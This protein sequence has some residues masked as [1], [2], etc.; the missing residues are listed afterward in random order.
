MTESVY[1]VQCGARSPSIANFCRNCGTPLVHDVEPES[2]KPEKLGAEISNEDQLSASADD[3][4]SPSRVTGSRRHGNPIQNHW[5]G[6]YSPPVALLVV[7]LAAISVVSMYWL[8]INL[9]NPV[10]RSNHWFGGL[11]LIVQGVLPIVVTFWFLVGLWRSSLRFGK[12][13][14]RPMI[15][16]PPTIGTAVV[17]WLFVVNG[18][19]IWHLIATG[20]HLIE[21]QGGV[22]RYAIHVVNDGKELILDGTFD[23]G[24]SR[25][26]REKLAKF[27]TARVIHLESGGGF[28]SEGVAVADIIEE[29]KL[30]TYTA[31]E[32]SSACVIAFSAGVQSWTPLI[33]QP[34]QKDKCFPQDER[35][36]LERSD[37]TQETDPLTGIQGQGRTGGLPG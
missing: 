32:C 19:L 30:K 24:L 6:I 36:A 18:S 2:P 29:H 9:Y 25:D 22:E 10:T 4:E 12:E 31:D 11:F 7:G 23:A 13:R 17:V 27:P 35:D 21:S 3:W 37:E 14:S 33:G 28:I 20:R 1:C 34:L 15:W 16:L 8:A 26:L 5:R